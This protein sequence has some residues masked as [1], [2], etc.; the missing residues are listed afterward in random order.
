MAWYFRGVFDWKGPKGIRGKGMP[1]SPQSLGVKDF[2][3][4]ARG[5]SRG[6]FREI[7]CSHFL[8]GGNSALVIGF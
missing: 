7:S 3:F 2:S 4:M 1:R 8:D 6:F 5:I